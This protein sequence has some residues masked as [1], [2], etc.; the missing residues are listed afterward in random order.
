MKM[1]K[2]LMMLLCG[3]LFLSSCSDDDDEINVSEK[4]VP[5][6]VLKSFQKQYKNVGDVKWEQKNQYHVARFNG[7]TLGRA[8][9]Y[10][11]SAWFTE[12]GTQHQADQDIDFNALP[13]VVKDALAAYMQQFYADWKVDDCEVVVRNGMSLIYVIEIEKGDLEREI[14]ISELGDVL[15]DVLDDDDDDDILPVLIPEELKA[16]LR[17]LFPETF[18]AISFL[19]LEIDDDEIEVD[20]MESGRHKEVEF[21]AQYNWVSTEYDVTMEEAMQMLAPEVLQK[22]LGMAKLAGIDLLDPEVQKGIEIEVKDHVTKGLTFEIEIEFGDLELEV[23]IDQNG[24]I[25]IDD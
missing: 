1:S 5:T 22:L 6:A 15:K 25:K 19:E 16:A 14:S 11:T 20:I 23:K 7:G 10:T 21:D 17:S 24:N 13:S 9:G 12:D 3:A 2:L 4:N 18:D 8:V